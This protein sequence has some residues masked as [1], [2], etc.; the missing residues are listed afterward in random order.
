MPISAPN[1]AAVPADLCGYPVDALLS[2]VD[3]PP[4]FLAV[5]PGGRGVVLKALES[6]CLLPKGSLH[7][8]IRDRLNR[9]RELALAGVANLH[10]VER[11]AAR[12]QQGCDAWLV[13]E[14]VR[15]QTF[16]Q[17]AT[18]PGRT[19]REVAV[20]ARELILTVDSLHLQGIVHGSIK[21]GNV[22]VSS[23][24]SIRLTHVSPLLYTD[25]SEDAMALVELLDATVRLRKEQQT[26]LGRIVR[27][28]MEGD[29]ADAQ[30][31]LRRLGMRLA[32]LT[33]AREARST[34]IV[35]RSSDARSSRR[36]SLLGA[37]AAA[38][39]A[40]GVGYV[41]WAAVGHPPVPLPK[42]VQDTIDVRVGRLGQ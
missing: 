8:N 41:V 3:Q 17:Y 37:A 24:G 7:P 11:D 33:E 10:G 9:V 22:I 27:E 30:A 35:R 5:G 25:P 4:S 26:P 15:G 20:A 13:W 34:E 16:D 32:A 12:P 19:P 36:R 39:L 1:K 23:H 29:W 38:L 28:A 31:V 40:L 18:A 2:A 14:Y 6:D 42:A 21:G